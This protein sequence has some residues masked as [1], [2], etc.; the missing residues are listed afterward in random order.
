MDGL[1]VVLQRVEGL[2]VGIDNYEYRARVVPSYQSGP[3][4]QLVRAH[5]SHAGGHWFEWS[6]THH[7]PLKVLSIL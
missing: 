1:G 6:R 5:V 2:A 4:F 3:L 7:R